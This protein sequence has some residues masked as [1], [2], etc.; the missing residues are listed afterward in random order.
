MLDDDVRGNAQQQGDAHTHEARKQPLDHGFRIEHVADVGLGGPYRAQDTDFL[1]PLKHGN[2]GD[3]RD[4]DRRDHERDRHE[5]DEHP[6]DHVDNARH[7][8]HEHPH[9]VGVDDLLFLLAPRLGLRVVGVENGLDLVLVLETRRVNIDLIGTRA[10]SPAELF[11]IVLVACRARR[12]H[13]RHEGSEFFLVHVHLER[14]GEFL[15]IDTHGIREILAHRGHRVI[16]LAF[17]L[18]LECAHVFLHH[19]ADRV[20]QISADGLL[21]LACEGAA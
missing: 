8:A 3:D 1:A 16:D 7:R 9:H 20:R 5:G 13:R 18:A 14:I 2:I 17:N 10:I 15:R 4:H 19:G 11:E 6:R 21:N 12:Y